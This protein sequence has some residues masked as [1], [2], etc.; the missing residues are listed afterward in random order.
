MSTL[1]PLITDSYK[2][3][4][5]QK[6]SSDSESHHYFYRNFREAVLDIYNCQN[7]TL[8]HITLLNN[9]GNGR[10][11]ESVRGNSGGLAI[12]YNMLPKNF[13][14]PILTVSNSIFRN[15]RALGFLSPER[16]VTGQVFLG[17]GGGMALYMNESFQ[18][19]HIEITGCTFEDNEARLFGGGLFI[20][21]NSYKSVQHV[22][23]VQSSQFS[24][25]VGRSGGAGIQ[26]SFLSSGN[27]NRPHSF[28]FSDCAFTG[29]RGQSGGG[30]Y[31]F[32]GI[33]RKGQFSG[34]SLIWDQVKMKRFPNFWRWKI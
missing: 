33:L 15:N 29:N 27:V 13:L 5:K 22:V 3:H 17:R 34:I 7:V 19:I 16:A 25:N 24:R 11:L 30:I 4:R 23:N 12:G 18:D 10:L 8:G 14:N 1:S 9:S 20:L 32:I 26:L 6:L 21:T 2:Q 31:I 28:T